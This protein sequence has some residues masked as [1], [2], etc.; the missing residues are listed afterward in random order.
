MRSHLKEIGAWREE[1]RVSHEEKERARS[2]N[3]NHP[4]VVWRDFSKW[5]GWMAD[6]EETERTFL[7][8]TVKKAL[9]LPDSAVAAG[10]AQNLPAKRTYSIAAAMLHR[11][12]PQMRAIVADALDVPPNSKHDAVLAGSMA[13]SGTHRNARGC[14]MS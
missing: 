9:V 1:L 6:R 13:S 10:L 11:L 4:Q 8:L 7:Q 3:L 2:L 5:K 12:D 14:P